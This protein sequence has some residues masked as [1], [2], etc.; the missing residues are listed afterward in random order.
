MKRKRYI[1]LFCLLFCL[2]GCQ[3]IQNI[4]TGLE[5]VFPWLKK[6]PGVPLTKGM[7]LVLE[8]SELDENGNILRSS[9][10]EEPISVTI[11]ETPYPFFLNRII[12]EIGSAVTGNTYS[13]QLMPE[14][15]YGI[16][17]DGLVV[18]IP[19]DRIPTNIPLSVGKRYTGE[20]SAG[21]KTFTVVSIDE[22]GIRADFN[23]PYSGLKVNLTVKILEIR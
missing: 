15:A 11:G 3:I 22:F 14:E 5:S 18:T 12:P 10:P 2:T 19:K 1:A 17:D 9:G 8:Y 20:T 6:D 21:R 13:I 16:Y 23:P 7:V 4:S